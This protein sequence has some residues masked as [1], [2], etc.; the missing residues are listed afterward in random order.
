LNVV[1]HCPNSNTKG[2][3]ETLSSNKV[4]DLTNQPYLFYIDNNKPHIDEM[5]GT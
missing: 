3:N 4:K 1:Q 5:E 2:N